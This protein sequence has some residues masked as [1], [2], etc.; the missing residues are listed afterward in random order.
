MNDK[1]EDCENSL[2]I[3][4]VNPSTLLSTIEPGRRYSFPK[5]TNN[6][7]YMISFVYGM[8][9]LAPF[10][11]ILSTLDFFNNETPNYPISFVISFAI[12]GVM[13]VVVLICLAYSEVGSNSVKINLTFAITAVLLMALPLLVSWSREKFSE[14]VCFWLT[15]ALLAMLG[16]FTAVS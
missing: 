11:A 6:T 8:A 1:W 2:L 16:A 4:R 10:N 9:I 3:D 12:N 15:V 14:S 7:I 5:D 13:V